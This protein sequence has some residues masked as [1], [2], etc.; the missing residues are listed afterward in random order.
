MMFDQILRDVGI[1]AEFLEGVVGQRRKTT[2]MKHMQRLDQSGLR[3]IEYSAGVSQ[4]R[5]LVLVIFR[6]YSAE[7]KYLANRRGLTYN[8][9]TVRCSRSSDSLKDSE[10]CLMRLLGWRVW[11]RNLPLKRYS[12][13]TYSSIRRIERLLP[14]HL[15]IYALQ[16][17]SII[18]ET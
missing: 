2:C 1:F 3:P 10:L 18:N 5:W 15:R 16:E 11:I 13:V 7:T 12:H 14:L 9:I 8:T 4:Q 6:I 17:T